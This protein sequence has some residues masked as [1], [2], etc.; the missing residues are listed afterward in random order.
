MLRRSILSLAVLAIASGSLL[1][2]EIRGIVKSVDPSQSTIILTVGDQERTIQVADNAPVL[3]MVTVQQRRRRVST[4]IQ[5]VG[6]GLN[7]LQP[8]MPVTLTTERRQGVETATQIQ[9]D[10]SN[11]SSGSGRRRRR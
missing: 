9:Q 7:S 2:A 1:A 11:Y 3:G 8:G 6:Q 10:N 5:Q 4:Q